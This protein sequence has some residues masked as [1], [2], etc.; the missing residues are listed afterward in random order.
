MFSIRLVSFVAW[1]LLPA[2]ICSAAEE[3]FVSL[4]NGRD[5][6]GWQ[7]DREL[8]S[9]QDGA[10][11]GV[12]RGPEHLEYNKFLI[13]DGEASD[14]ELRCEFRLEGKNNSGV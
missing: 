2:T 3:G 13:W 8:W 9:V 7:G 4:F 12:T 1:I 6:S 10:I 11:T 5:L 14:F